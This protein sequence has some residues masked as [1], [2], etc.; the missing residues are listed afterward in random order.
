MRKI[1]PERTL[2]NGASVASVATILLAEVNAKPPSW[3]LT[4][5]GQGT[6]GKSAFG[7]SLAAKAHWTDTNAAKTFS[8][9]CF[10][11]DAF[12][13]GFVGRLAWIVGD[14]IRQGKPGAFAHPAKRFP[15][16]AD[17]SPQDTRDGRLPL[18]SRID[19]GRI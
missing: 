3:A 5:L 14:F 12:F 17:L 10:F 8:I 6:K 11:M 18:I 9:M 1:S 7:A 2:A 16:S 4:D 19:S 15:V 13:D